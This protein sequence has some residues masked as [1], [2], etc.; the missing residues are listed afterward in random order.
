MDDSLHLWL[1]IAVVFVIVGTV[2]FL[3]CLGSTDYWGDE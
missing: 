1:N 2:T 3:T